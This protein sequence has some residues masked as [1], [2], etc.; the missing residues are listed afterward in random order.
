M[1]IFRLL[2]SIYV[3]ND[4]ANKAIDDTDKK[5]KGLGATFENGIATLARWGV[6][7]AA[8]G[9][10]AAL[11]LGTI[12]AKAAVKFEKEMAN[13]STLLD[14]DVKKRI[15]ELGE[16]VKQLAKDT[17]TSTSLLT[18]GLYQ[19][20]SAFGD[21]A[22]SMGI[23]ETA[24]KGAAAGNATVTDSVNLLAA[25]TK[26]YG[27]TSEE[28]AL[29][30]SD[31]AFLTVKLGQT[32]FPELASSMGKVIPLAATMKV[33]QEE[34]FGAMATLTGVTGG[35]A[36]VT[37]QLRGAIQG[38]MQ[39]SKQMADVL[40]KLGYENG[41]VALESEGLGGILNSL[42]DA[43]GGNEI[44]FAGLF[45][46]VEA[47]SAVL[48]L[49]GAQAENFAEKVKA[50]GDAAGST[51]E[52]FVRQQATVSAMWAKIKVSA[53][54]LF[55]SLGE[56]LLP[57]L[58]TLLGFVLANLPAMEAT[59]DKVFSAIS[60]V[61][62]VLADG[63][64]ILIG[65]LKQWGND[66]QEI[67]NAVQGYFKALFELLKILFDTFVTIAT[68]I[69]SVY[70]DS[71]MSVAKFVWDVVGTVFKTSL[72]LMTDLFNI[73]S[74]LFRGDWEALWTGVKNFFTHAW[75]GMYGVLKSII[76]LMIRA[77]NG[78]VERLNKLEF[79]IP[80]WV[81]ILGG[82]KWGFDLPTI[83]EL[84]KGGRVWD[85]G[86]FLVGERGPEILS[87][88]KGATVTPLSKAGNTTTIY[89]TVYGNWEEI[90]RELDALG[91]VI[92]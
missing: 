30:A 21:S 18:D 1:E 17:G 50:M 86:A 81:P 82:M 4:K 53:D 10:A 41:Q 43:V 65:W 22:A 51:E 27:D 85:D 63:I 32:S 28:A 83:P 75:E 49:T 54:V 60:A 20:V 23:L 90:R 29:K 47:K 74:A 35:T 25:V 7:A 36:E 6:A 76:N 72:K 48:A 33:S 11:A 26:G 37:T 80:D 68:A 19:V 42:K 67:A 31:L 8:A 73:F 12:A 58:S 52:A 89:M 16:N 64:G 39:P 44:A 69:W 2:G 15:S 87:G 59:F 9:A 70:G 34:L 45:G 77:I 84:Y 91:V 40:K 38:F 92:A 14:G 55:I 5:G 61:I 79:E 13:V 88:M 62:S 3:E 46:S 56:K 24:S 66:N 57:V 71:I 78:M